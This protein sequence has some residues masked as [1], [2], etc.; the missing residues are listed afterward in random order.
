[1]EQEFVGFSDSLDV[2]AQKQEDII[3]ADND[4]AVKMNSL[5]PTDTNSIHVT[6]NDPSAPIVMLF[7]GQTSGKTMTLVRLA[8]FLRKANYSFAVD[9]TFTDKEVW[10][11]VKNARN[12][13]SMLQTNV[14]LK[15]TDHNDFL[16]IQMLDEDKNLICQ[17]LEAAGEDYFPLKDSNR[18]NKPFPGYMQGIFTAANKKIWIF[19]LD[20]KMSTDKDDRLAYVDRIRWIKRNQS[21][22]GD[23]YI[24][25]FNKIDDVRVVDD[26]MVTC[27]KMYPGIFDIFKNPSIWPWADPYLC[28]FVPFST[29]TYYEPDAD[30]VIAYHPSNDEYPAALW[31]AIVDCIKDR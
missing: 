25:L 23:K 1:M 16:F 14:A 21:K 4:S 12:F 30:N 11:Y 13:N 2:N 24:L 7:G 17:I 22:K 20:P 26:A 29:G 18:V 27:G 6:V 28:K 5:P 8:R 19:I 3:V 31:E 15:G 9:D 10:E